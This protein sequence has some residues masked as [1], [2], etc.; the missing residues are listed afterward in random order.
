MF[1]INN[2]SNKALTV[3]IPQYAYQQ[4]KTKYINFTTSLVRYKIHFQ[5]K[6]SKSADKDNIQS[7]IQTGKN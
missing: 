1:R 5:N 2:H 7:L 3:L 4:R 6:V